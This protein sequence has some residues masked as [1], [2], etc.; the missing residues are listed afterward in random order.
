MTEP[1]VPVTMLTGRHHGATLSLPRSEAKTLVGTGQARWAAETPERR[2]PETP[3][4]P[5]AR[6]LDT[7]TKAQLVELAE[8]EGVDVQRADGEDGAPLKSDYLRALG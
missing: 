8:A 5:K 6:P 2:T 3:E 1:R 4:T 7:L